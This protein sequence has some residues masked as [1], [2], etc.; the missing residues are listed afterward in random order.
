VRTWTGRCAGCGADM[1]LD[2]ERRV[3]RCDHCGAANLVAG[4]LTLPVARLRA[5]LGADDVAAAVARF[6]RARDLEQVPGVAG[7]TEQWVPYWIPAAA[8]AGTPGRIAVE[9]ADPLLAEL[10]LPAGETEPLDPAVESDPRWPWP[11]VRGGE[12]DVLRY[13]PFFRVRLAAEGG[14]R[15]AWVERVDGVVRPTSPLNPRRL[16][17][18]PVLG[19]LLVLFGAATLALGAFAPH[20]LLAL[21]GAAAAGLALGWPVAALSR[22]R[23]SGDDGTGEGGPT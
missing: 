21:G 1:P 23:G 12:G 14:E 19:G 11:T 7:C 4:R 3:V 18:G 22:R 20:P 13:V 10:P 6:A 16:R 2:A 15:D 8:A 9:A 17:F 5:V